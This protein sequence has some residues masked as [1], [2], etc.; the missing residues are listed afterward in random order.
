MLQSDQIDNK[1]NK[2]TINNFNKQLTKNNVTPISR[3]TSPIFNNK[4]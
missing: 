2:T 4:L 1:A 3:N